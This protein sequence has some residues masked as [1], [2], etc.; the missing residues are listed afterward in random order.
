MRSTISVAVIA[1]ILAGCTTTPSRLSSA[2]KQH[3]GG[4]ADSDLGLAT[5]AL[6]ALNSNQVDLAIS[7]AERAVEKTPRD[8]GFRTILGN[9]YFAAGRFHSAE[10]AFEDAL[11]LYGNQPKSMLKLALVQ[12]AQGKNN[13]A[14]RTLEAARGHIDPSDFGLALAL[15]GRPTDAIAVLDQAARSD[16]ADSKVRQ[17][18]AL[19]YALAGDWQQA[20]LIAS[21]DVGAAELDIRLQE[22]MALANPVRASDQVASLLRVTPAPSDAGQ[23]VRL[24]LR[25]TGNT[26]TAEAAPAKAAPVEVAQ[27]VPLPAPVFEAQPLTAQA[28][29]ELPAI[30]VA[31]AAPAPAFEAAP[32][33]PPPPNPLRVAAASPAEAPL[34]MVET[35]RKMVAKARGAVAR[36]SPVKAMLASAS[37]YAKGKSN[38][39]VQLGAYDDLAGVQAAWDVA[40]RTFASLRNFAPMS[41]RYDSGKRIFYRLSVKGF[42]SQSEAANLC[43]SLKRSG[44]ACFVRTIAGDKPIQLASR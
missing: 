16:D 8:A 5:R 14:L 36:K 32:P 41:A 23:P 39:V 12:I 20:R 21:Q 28:I 38:S 3:F 9:A 11:M 19:A 40:A 22:W 35:A 43:A 17:N 24:A 30:K 6:A 1:A 18:L 25:Q 10:Q 34:A 33:A 31:E 26:R 15:A 42:A 27:A 4:R 44:R 29:E 37:T 13:D 2:S 7:L